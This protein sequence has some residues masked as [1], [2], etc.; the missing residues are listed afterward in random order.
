M[1]YLGLVKKFVTDGNEVAKEKALDAVLLYVD[2]IP[3]AA[4]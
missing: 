2:N 4:K 1:N 3:A